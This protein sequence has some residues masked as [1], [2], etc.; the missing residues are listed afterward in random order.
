MSV[1]YKSQRKGACVLLYSKASAMKVLMYRTTPSVSP[2]PV[3]EHEAL[4]KQS[5]K[6]M[7]TKRK[8]VMFES[9]MGYEMKTVVTE[10]VKR[11]YNFYEGIVDNEAKIAQALKVETVSTFKL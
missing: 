2:R 6:H 10:T 11:L 8:V 4:T 7:T 1:S 5:E 9:D 3:V